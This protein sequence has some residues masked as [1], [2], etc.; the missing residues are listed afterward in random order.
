MEQQEINGVENQKKETLVEKMLKE[1]GLNDAP[2]IRKAVYD[3]LAGGMN[4]DKLGLE[5]DL[6]KMNIKGFDVPRDLV[7]NALKQKTTNQMSIFILEKLT[8]IKKDSQGDKFLVK[9]PILKEQAVPVA[10]YLIELGVK[11]P[12]TKSDKNE[13]IYSWPPNLWNNPPL[14]NEVKPTGNRYLH[15]TNNPKIKVE[16]SWSDQYHKNGEA[17]GT[18]P[19]VQEIKLVI[20][21]ETERVE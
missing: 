17:M 6:N 4:D 13:A 20:F 16:F 11:M 10:K 5:E 12:N 15:D 3:D 1:L 14:Y 8:L 21:P 2:N 19:T 18:Y 7:E 9:V